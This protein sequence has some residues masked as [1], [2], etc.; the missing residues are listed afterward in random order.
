MII[1]LSVRVVA[2]QYKVPTLSKAIP[3]SGQFSGE[4]DA[5]WYLYLLPFVN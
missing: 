4:R 3:I 1:V 2:P 5:M